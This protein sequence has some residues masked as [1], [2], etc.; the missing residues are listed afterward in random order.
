MN[1]IVSIFY[2]TKSTFDYLDDQYED[3]LNNRNT[4]IF[5][6]IG[7][8]SAA[9]S[10][11]SGDISR[12]GKIWIL[13]AF[14]IG[15]GL[16]FIIG[17]YFISYIIY[18]ISKLLNGQAKI[19]D[20]QTVVAYALLP[21]LLR[22]P[23]IAYFGFTGKYGQFVGLDLYVL[24]GLYILLS[25]LILKIAIQGLNRFCNYGIFK[26]IINLSPF[27]ILSVIMNYIY[28]IKNLL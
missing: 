12:F 27:I 15:A 4:L 6:S 20:I 7:L 14:A 5:Y 1:T 11:F 19:I 18:W 23:I 24:N 25:L 10:Y 2:K 16:G 9:D 17:K 21:R 22:L 13:F 3:V 8:I 26:A 28:F